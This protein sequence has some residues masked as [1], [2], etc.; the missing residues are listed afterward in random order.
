MMDRA[1]QTGLGVAIVG[2]VVLFG[3]LSV[4]FLATPNPLDLKQHPIEVT[5]SDE[6]GLES[7]APVASHEEPAP[8]LAEEEGPVEPTP[9]PPPEP[10]PAPQPVPK[11]VPT[12][13]PKTG[14]ALTRCCW[15]RAWAT[16]KWCACS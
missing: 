11:P 2:H 9:P 1:E 15:L 16:W 4:G 12:P 3:L 14:L 7:Q 6:V 5:L 13:A 10:V 8:K